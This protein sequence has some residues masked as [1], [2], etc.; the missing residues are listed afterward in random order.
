MCIVGYD[1]L[2]MYMYYSLLVARYLLLSFVI[3]LSLFICSAGYWL[4]VI[5][6]VSVCYLLLFIYCYCWLFVVIYLFVLLISC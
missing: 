1:L 2:V 4:L 5:Y 3:S 6:F